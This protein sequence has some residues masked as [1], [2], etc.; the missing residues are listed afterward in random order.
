L[1][2]TLARPLHPPP[3][4]RQ[5]VLLPPHQ[6]S[7]EVSAQLLPLLSLA[8]ATC[9]LKARPRPAR[10]PFESHLM[11]LAFPDPIASVSAL[12][13]GPFLPAKMGAPPLVTGVAKRSQARNVSVPAPRKISGWMK[14]EYWRRLMPM[15]HVTAFAGT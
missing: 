1:Y 13:Q 12:L 2:S 9:V 11:H 4:H 7:W 8:D 5:D 15:S 10:L 3:D 14:T 6:S